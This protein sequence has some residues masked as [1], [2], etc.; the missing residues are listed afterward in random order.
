M[1]V[2]VQAQGW[3]LR[4][5]PL[6]EV[7]KSTFR[8]EAKLIGYNETPIDVTATNS[9]GNIMVNGDLSSTSNPVIR[10]LREVVD[11][12]AVSQQLQSS[13]GGQLSGTFENH[14][15]DSDSLRTGNIKTILVFRCQILELAI[16][17]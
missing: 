13:S 4:S 11:K 16:L 12:K 17:C 1:G 14:D 15:C 6:E 10:P 9:I 3:K 2:D 5:K 8:E 7:L